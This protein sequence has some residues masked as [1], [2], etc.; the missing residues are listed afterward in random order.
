MTSAL[1]ARKVSQCEGRGWGR[2][3][4]APFTVTNV[5][6]SMIYTDVNESADHF[7]L[8]A[9]T[10]L[11][12]LKEVLQRKYRRKQTRKQIEKDKVKT[13]PARDLKTWAVEHSTKLSSPSS[14]SYVREFPANLNTTSGYDRK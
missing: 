10:F 1:R 4:G 8:R 3:G 7:P 11:E 5:Y 6:L 13:P 9:H 2:A 14:V 12:Y